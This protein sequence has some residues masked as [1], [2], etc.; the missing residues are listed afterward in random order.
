VAFL[1]KLTIYVPAVV[2]VAV[3]ILWRWR[4]EEQN[5][6][7]LLWQVFWSAGLALL[8]GGLWFGRNLSVYG[9]PDFLGQMAH[10]RVV[11]GQLRTGEFI[12]HYGLGEYLRRYLTTT[13]NSFWGQFG[14]MGVPMPHRVYGLITAFLVIDGV[15]V[16]LLLTR[17]RA[18]LN[19]A[20]QQ[21]AGLWALGGVAAAT[22]LNY[23]YYNLSFFQLQGRYLFTALIPLGVLVVA[24]LFG[25]ALLLRRGLPGD[26]WYDLFEWL[27]LVAL[28]WLPLLTVFALFRYVMPNLS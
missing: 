14:W 17:F 13:Y 28:G 26:R 20:K 1:T 18:V 7:W 3:V 23:V 5:W 10:G 2:I 16:T 21:R 6:R 11:V 4:I 19:I 8:I 9:W 25:W 12:D 22:A 15:G 24:G 27:P